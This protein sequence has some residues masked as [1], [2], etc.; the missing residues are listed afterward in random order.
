MMNNV[1]ANAPL[2][3]LKFRVILTALVVSSCFAAVTLLGVAGTKNSAGPAPA[4]QGA[5]T[6]EWLAEFNRE[7]PIEVQFT[8]LRRTARGGNHTSSG[9]MALSELHGL[10]REQAFGARNDV[11]FRLVREAGTFECE[12]S[13]REG[14]GAGHWTLTPN[15][16][17]VS[18]MR[19]R[20]R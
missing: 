13:F 7:N 15:Q 8:I 5:I 6:G 18:L 9:G 1:R 20:L 2:P 12:G 10:T 17:F 11:R 4:I 3:T 14:K 16:N 19:A